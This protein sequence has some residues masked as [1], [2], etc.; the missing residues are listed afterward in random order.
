[1]LNLSSSAHLLR[2][3]DTFYIEAKKELFLQHLQPPLMHMYLCTCV[4]KY[5][6]FP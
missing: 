3:M 5:L 1:M 4:C 6:S 2:K